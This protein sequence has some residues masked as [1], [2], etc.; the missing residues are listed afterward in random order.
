MFNNVVIPESFSVSE[1]SNRKW[2]FTDLTGYA[3]IVLAILS[4]YFMPTNC[5]VAASSY[6]LSVLLD[7]FD[8]Y[9]ARYFNQSEFDHLKRAVISHRQDI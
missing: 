3:R 1:I 2:Y 4:F 8:G 6:L 5:V 7:E 9:A